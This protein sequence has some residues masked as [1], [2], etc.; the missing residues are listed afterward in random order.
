MNSTYELI[1]ATAERMPE[2]VALRF[3]QQADPESA[4]ITWCYRQLHEQITRFANWLHSVGVGPGDTV[5]IVLP[6][7]PQ[8]HFAFWGAEAAAIANPINPMLDQTHMG[9]IM[10]KVDTRVLVTLAPGPQ[11]DGWVK[12]EALARQLP[13]LKYILTVDP[14]QFIDGA[15]AAALPMQL[16]AAK[17]ADFDA[18]IAGQPGERLLSAR[19]FLS[20]DVAAYFHTG[21][22]TGIPKVAQHTHGNEVA[23][24][25]SLALALD[26][27]G[28]AFLCG[29]PLFHVNGIMVTGLLPFLIGGSVLLATASGYRGQG[30]FKNFWRLIERHGINYFSG[31]PT[32]YSSLL[33]VPIGDADVS[34]LRY[35]IC[36]AAPL[37]PELIR[38]F[39]GATG[40][41]LLE[42]YGLTEAA[43]AST[44]N[45]IQGERCI[46]SIGQELPGI[47]VKAVELD[48][49][50]S[51]VRDCA[52]DV[53][54]QLVIRGATVFPGYLDPDN[55][56]GLFLDGGWVKT[57]DL[58]RR[59]RRGYFWLAGR[60]KDLIIRSGH[61]IDPK[62]IEEALQQHPAVAV[63]AAVGRPDRHAG[64]LPVAYVELRQGQCIS[65]E[66]LEIHAAARISEKAAIPKAIHIIERMPLTAVGK[67]FKPALVWRETGKVFGD[68][69]SALPGIASSKVEVG[70][71]ARYG[72][73]ASVSIEPLAGM[74]QA[75]LAEA[76]QVALGAFTT[77]FEISF[78]EVA[79]G[80]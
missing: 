47:E 80:V 73:L 31:V 61:N 37:S 25:Q 14:A 57:G 28:G 29:L 23:M 53:V 33:E 74:A 54:G 7:L 24:A 11:N 50:G 46:G 72:A 78:T 70:A 8:Y 49:S 34:S 62:A 18:A 52:D 64:E 22:T 68:A 6:N 48:S 9:A 4:A 5:S 60:A 3:L 42:G 17:V 75:A 30:V 77:R 43:C 76:I 51:Y 2:Q 1:A 12:V 21:G 39:E 15:T 66:E 40:I 55:N 20:T 63:V 58:G 65:V 45:P 41:R 35:G 36:G 67:V 69:L 26:I 10:Q 16:G 38:R 71:D 13:N 32:V 44:M 79:P 56:I 59:D 27:Q 19:S